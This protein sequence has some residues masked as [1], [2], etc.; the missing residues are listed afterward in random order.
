[1]SR[2]TTA[3]ALAMVRQAQ[4]RVAE[5]DDLYGRAIKAAD[6]YL[7]LAVIAR[8]DYARFLIDQRRGGEARAQL[9]IARGFYAHP[10]VSRR[11]E[12]VDE[13]LRRCDEVR[14]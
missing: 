3:V 9:Q 14:A 1:L 8:V 4:G 7:E 2:S 10:F 11:R 6:G 5:A 13:L 12:V